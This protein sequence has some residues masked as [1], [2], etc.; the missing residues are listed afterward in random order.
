M[1]G[2]PRFDA[3]EATVWQWDRRAEER[4]LRLAPTGKGITGR[5]LPDVSAILIT[6]SKAFSPFGDDATY[7]LNESKHLQRWCDLN[8]KCLVNLPSRKGSRQGWTLAVGTAVMLN[9]EAYS[10]YMH[11]VRADE[12]ELNQL[13]SSSWNAVSDK[14]FIAAASARSFVDVAFAKPLNF[15]V[16]SDITARPHLA[17]I[18]SCAE[19]WITSLGNL[20]DVGKAKAP[21]IDLL[22]SLIL[23]EFEGEAHHKDWKEEYDDWYHKV[24]KG[25]EEGV[26]DG[27]RNG[28]LAPGLIAPARCVRTDAC[29]ASPQP[30][31]GHKHAQGF[32][33]R[34]ESKRRRG[35]WLRLLRLRA[36]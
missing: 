32:G 11:Q 10:E 4:K 25:L 27:D 6:L 3:C 18:M 20:D 22:A 33:T 23:S 26:Q 5:D 12:N 30:R 15:F 7:Y 1:E 29:H 24:G 17:R 13:I 8:D 14:Y 31:R 28:L 19:K 16:H 2:R 21:P 34:A 35:G 9:A 36:P